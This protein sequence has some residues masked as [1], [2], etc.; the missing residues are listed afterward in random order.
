MAHGYKKKRKKKSGYVSTRGEEGGWEGKRVLKIFTNGTA[1]AREGGYHGAARRG[2]GGRRPVKRRGTRSRRLYSEEIRRT[3]KPGKAL[4]VSRRASRKVRERELT[5]HAVPGSE[6]SSNPGFGLIERRAARVPSGARRTFA[7]IR[8]VYSF[9][10]DICPEDVQISTLCRGL[11]R[12]S[13]LL[14]IQSRTRTA[15]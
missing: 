6:G 8:S 13:R 14:G 12:L 11:E 10:R 5:R 3:R 2:A 7:V 15:D 1:T 9:Q 4:K